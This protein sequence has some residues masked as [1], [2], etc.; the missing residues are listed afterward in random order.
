MESGAAR[1]QNNGDGIDLL[2]KLK[3]IVMFSVPRMGLCRW[4]FII[5]SAIGSD[6]CCSL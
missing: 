1:Q 4:W 2:L 3:A 5:L 6:G